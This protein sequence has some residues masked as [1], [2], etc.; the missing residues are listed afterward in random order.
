VAPRQGNVLKQQFV[1]FRLGENIFVLR[2]IQLRGVLGGDQRHRLASVLRLDGGLSVEAVARQKDRI[3]VGVE[4]FC[5]TAAAI[6][7]MRKPRHGTVNGFAPIAVNP[8]AVKEQRKLAA[9]ETLET[10]VRVLREK[11]K[12]RRRPFIP[13]NLESRLV[14]DYA[15]H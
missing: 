9:P 12:Q 1:L 11:S 3:G 8:C 10:A 2:R 13:E 14:V 4:R 7:T 6:K 5:F 15:R